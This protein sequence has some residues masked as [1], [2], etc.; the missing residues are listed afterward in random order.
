V[1]FPSLI[2]GRLKSRYKRFLA[3]V[4]LSDGDEVVCAHCP[5]TG[6]MTGC[7][8]D[9]APVWLS[10]HTNPARKLSWTWELVATDTGLAC[11]HSALA[12]QVVEEGLRGG[13]FP[14]VAQPGKSIRREVRLGKG[15]RMDFFL[16][17]DQGIFLE[18]KSVTLHLGGGLGA[19][20]D[21]ISLRATK[22]LQEMQNALHE[23][24]R[25]V[26]VF[27][28]MH[29]AIER[30]IPATDIDPTYSQQ[31][32]N[33]IEAGLEVYALFNDITLHG[34]YPQAVIRLESCWT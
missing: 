17:S 11:I 23:G 6:A 30:V 7:Q 31:L 27:C 3:D 8:L 24:Y 32:M 21:A 28:V 12:N 34:I 9:N 13:Y 2:E 33:A 18:V 22:H 20:P 26:L 16:P 4:E 25:A 10:Y 14:S 5:N 1:N 19:F 29:T 15:S